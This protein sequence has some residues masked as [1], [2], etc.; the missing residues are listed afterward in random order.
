MEVLENEADRCKGSLQQAIKSYTNLRCTNWNAANNLRI[1][2]HDYLFKYIVKKTK[3]KK[4]LKSN[5]SEIHKTSL[6]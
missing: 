3:C 6:Q 5:S 4:H 2:E 1:R